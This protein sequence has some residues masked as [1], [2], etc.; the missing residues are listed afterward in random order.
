MPKDSTLLYLPAT[1]FMRLSDVL[2]FIPVSKTTWWEGVKNGDYPA[3]IKLGRNMTAW[4]AEDIR[5]LIDRLNQQA[6]CA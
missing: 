2:R 3:P 5:D 1:G 6:Q 4:R